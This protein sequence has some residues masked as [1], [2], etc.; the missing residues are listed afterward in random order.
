[1]NKSILYF[2]QFSA[3]TPKVSETIKVTKRVQGITERILDIY[4]TAPFWITMGT[5]ML[6]C[7]AAIFYYFQEMPW[8]VKVIVELLDVY[9]LYQS[10]DAAREQFRLRKRL[11]KILEKKGYNEK[12]MSK[13]LY[14]WC[15]VQTAKVATKKYWCLDRYLEFSEKNKD[16]R[17]M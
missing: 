6:F 2:N 4:R 9:I 17:T 13:T 11:E 16:K 1:M 10:V 15:D 14:T 5:S 3:H 7:I 8:S 12:I